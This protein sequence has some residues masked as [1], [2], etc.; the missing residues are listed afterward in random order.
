MNI[1]HSESFS[2]SIDRPSILII[3]NFWFGSNVTRTSSFNLLLKKENMIN[4]ILLGLLSVIQVF[5]RLFLVHYVK[6]AQVR[7]F[8]WSL[9]SHSRTEY[10]EIRSISPYSVRIWKMRTRKNSIFGHF[11][12][13][14]Y[15]H[16]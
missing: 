15:D 6:S 5:F 2:D 8:F 1:L 10:G 3:Q 16:N 11:S 9:F 14:G 4:L 13:N 12:R 7:R